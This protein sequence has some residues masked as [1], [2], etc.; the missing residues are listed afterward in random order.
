MRGVYRGSIIV[1][2]LILLALS[3]LGAGSVAASCEEPTDISTCDGNLDSYGDVLGAIY[4]IA[5]ETVRYAGITSLAVGGMLYLGT[6][7]SSKYAKNGIWLIV[8]GS[9]LTILY[10]GYATFFQL[11]QIIAE[12]GD[13]NFDE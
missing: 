4:L 8:G 7:K 11:I 10:F 3:T 12:G 6:S 2:I 5:R 13:V 9:A 1:A